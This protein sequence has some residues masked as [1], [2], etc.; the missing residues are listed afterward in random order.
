[1]ARSVNQST[2]N[3]LKQLDIM[4]ASYNKFAAQLK[5]AKL[6]EPDRQMLNASLLMLKEMMADKT[7]DIRRRLRESQKY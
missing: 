1:M 4:L 5:D 7:R 2:K 6:S 3:D